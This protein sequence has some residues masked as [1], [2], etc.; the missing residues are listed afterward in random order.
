MPCQHPR[1]NPEQSKKVAEVFNNYVADQR[2]NTNVTDQEMDENYA[3]R[4]VLMAT[5]EPL[6]KKAPSA[7]SSKPTAAPKP[8]KD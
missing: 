2:Q 4:R 1:L 6:E 7:K 3:I 5:P 8:A